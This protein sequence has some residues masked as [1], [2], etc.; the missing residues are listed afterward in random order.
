MKTNKELFDEL[1]EFIESKKCDPAELIAILHRA[2]HIFGYL[3]M[4]VQQFIADKLGIN[5]SK[6]YGVVTFYSFFTMVPKGKYVINICLGTACFVRGSD[7][8]LAKVE[9][10]LKI[11]NGETTPDG[12]FTVTSLRCVGACGLAPVMQI[13]GKTYGNLK[14]EDVEGILAQY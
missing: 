10:I 8:L 11:K 14:P 7:K 1:G 5:V 4:E 9:E 12:K 13:N 2:Q 3:P 6:V